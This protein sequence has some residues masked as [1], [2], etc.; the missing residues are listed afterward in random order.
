MPLANCPVYA[1]KKKPALKPEFYSISNSANESRKHCLLL[2]GAD[3]AKTIRGVKDASNISKKLSSGD[4][5]N[6][7]ICT[8]L[9]VSLIRENPTKSTALLEV[10]NSLF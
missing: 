6:L 1:K 8:T 4:K 2:F 9:I 7:D 3:L 5:K 10:T